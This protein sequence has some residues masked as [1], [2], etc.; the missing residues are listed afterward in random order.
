MLLNVVKD[1]DTSP[2]LAFTYFPMVMGQGVESANVPY[3]WAEP[4]NPGDRVTIPLTE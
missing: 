3:T 4:A 2:D 1:P